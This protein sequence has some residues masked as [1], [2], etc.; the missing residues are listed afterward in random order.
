MEWRVLQ[1]VNRAYIL[2]VTEFGTIMIVKTASH[3]NGHSS[4]RFESTSGCLWWYVVNES[5]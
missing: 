1:V 3:R 5:V 4:S 2:S